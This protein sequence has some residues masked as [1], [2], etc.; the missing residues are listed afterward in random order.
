VDEIAGRA[1]AGGGPKP[2]YGNVVRRGQSFDQ[3]V[4]MLGLDGS[5]DVRVETGS[6]NSVGRTGD[7]PSKVVANVKRIECFGDGA[8]RSNEV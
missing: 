5:D 7:R 1:L 6:G 4:D 2:I 8:K 3:R